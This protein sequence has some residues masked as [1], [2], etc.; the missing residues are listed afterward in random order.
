M[1]LDIF[2]IFLKD[3]FIRERRV[4]SFEGMCIPEMSRKEIMEVVENI[5]KI[6]TLLSK[7]LRFIK[8]MSM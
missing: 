5:N 1:L 2:G 3:L 8:G 4:F 6:P 7:F